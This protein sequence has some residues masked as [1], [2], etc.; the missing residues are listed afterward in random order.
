MF[1]FLDFFSAYSCDSCSGLCVSNGYRMIMICQNLF[2]IKNLPILFV[3]CTP[4]CLQKLFFDEN[5]NIPLA[6]RYSFSVNEK[7]LAKLQAHHM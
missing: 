2:G 6:S 3:S 4:E 7:F 5:E 1:L